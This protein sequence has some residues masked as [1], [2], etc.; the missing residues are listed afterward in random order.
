MCYGLTGG[1]PYHV[2]ETPDT[3]VFALEIRRARS[4]LVLYLA[5]VVVVTVVAAV[6]IEGNSWAHLHTHCFLSASLVYSTL[7][8]RATPHLL[9]TTLVAPQM[10]RPPKC[11]ILAISR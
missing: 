1:P 9:G 4:L 11:A 5:F 3:I 7:R 6:V 2:A 8:T 10:R